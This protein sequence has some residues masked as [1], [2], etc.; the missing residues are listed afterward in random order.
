[1]GDEGGR[2]AKRSVSGEL[3]GAARLLVHATTKVTDI[4]QGM[5]VTI[6]GGPAVLGAPLAPV[7]KALTRPTYAAIRGVTGLV[8]VG[9]DRVFAE[10]EP[11]LG[12]RATSEEYDAVLAALNGVVGDHLA[13]TRNPLALEMDLLVDGAP[14]TVT[15]EGLRRALPEANGRVLLL[16]HGSSM[17]ARGWRRRGHDHGEALARDHGY[18]PVYLRY[19]SGLHVSTNGAQLADRLEALLAA[20]P[21][22]VTSLTLLGFSMG[23]L[24]ARAAVREAEARELAWRARLSSMVFL[25]TPHHGAPLERVGNLVG[26]LFDASRY[27]APLRAL[28]RLRSAGVTD[29]R[30][31]SVLAADWQGRDRFALGGDERAPCPLP[32][33]VACFA[34]AGTRAFEAP[35][36]LRDV[37]ALS[38]DGLVPVESALGRHRD[39]LLDLKFPLSNQV[40]VARAG[41]LDLLGHPDAYRAMAR[42]LSDAG[43]SP[44]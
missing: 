24:V 32:E 40:V 10:L 8:G 1:M 41:H 43:G 30:F 29:L 6:A 9:L 25:G 4:V 35:A 12:A 26:V 5:H 3:R 7:V 20:W 22:P 19:N 42:W 33:G 11:A 38:G 28:P 37:A 27:S 18:S 21:V 39:S 17:D 13:E 31:G 16:L 23:G 34:L 44:G 2:E 15:P 36:D 14:V